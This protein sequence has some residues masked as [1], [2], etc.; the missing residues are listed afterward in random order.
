MIDITELPGDLQDYIWSKFHSDLRKRMGTIQ[1][2]LLK[3]VLTEANVICVLDWMAHMLQ[4]P[5][6]KPQKA[7]LLVGPQGCGKNLFATLLTLLFGH[8]HVFRTTT[9]SEHF[10]ESMEGKTLVHLD[11]CDIRNE[12]PH[13][14]SLISDKMF[15]I[16]RFGQHPYD[17]PSY[18]RVLLTIEFFS[19]LLIH[20]KAFQQHFTIVLCESVSFSPEEFYGAMNDPI[21]LAAFRQHLME[22]QVSPEL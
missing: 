6:I 13:I 15:T 17:V 8:D 1:Y 7:I 5:N 12:L 22:R 2:H 4:Y 21:Q 3:L 19:P 10:N 14:Y 11:G 16:R 9:L 20:S 18:H